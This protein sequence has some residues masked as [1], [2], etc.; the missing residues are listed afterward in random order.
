MRRAGER[1]RGV[2]GECH[3]ACVGYL[4][5]AAR[6]IDKQPFSRFDSFGNAFVNAAGIDG[7]L[8]TPI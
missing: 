3:A 2:G 4:M 7:F 5:E 6:D 1:M 8:V